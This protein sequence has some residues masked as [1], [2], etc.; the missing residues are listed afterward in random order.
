MTFVNISTHNFFERLDIRLMFLCLFFYQILFIFWGI[1]LADMGWMAIFCQQIFNDP[2]S[3]H[4]CFGR[5]LTGIV[6]GVWLHL[7]SGLGLLGLKIFGV[8]IFT[9]S[10][11]F[12]YNLL[13]DD[14]NKNM[15]KPG[16]IFMTLLVGPYWAYLG[17]HYNTITALFFILM[18]LFLFK[19]LKEK[20][21]SKIFVSGIFLC[22]NTFA[23]LPN[24]TGVVILLPVIYY[25]YHYNYSFKYQFKIIISFFLGFAL[26]FLLLV[27]LLK[28]LKHDK[29]FVDTLMGTIN[30]SNRQNTGNSQEEAHTVVNLVRIYFSQFSDILLLIFKVAIFSTIYLFASQFMKSK[31]LFILPFVISYLIY[32]LIDENNFLRVTEFNIYYGIVLLFSFF[33]LIDKRLSFNQ[34]FL[35]ILGLMLFFLLPIGSSHALINFE[36][37]F[38]FISLP[39][40]IEQFLTIKPFKIFSV[41][42][43]V[44]F[45][46][47]EIISLA[48]K[49]AIILS[50]TTCIVLSIYYS[51][52][53]DNKKYSLYYPIESPLSCGIFSSKDRADVVNEL[54]IASSKYVR[55]NDYVIAYDQIPMFYYLTGTKPFLPNFNSLA[56]DIPNGKTDILME[57]SI[58]EKKV[59]PVIIKQKINFWGDN[60]TNDTIGMSVRNNNFEKFI[61]QYPYRQVWEN[62][63]FQIFVPDKELR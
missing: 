15:L 60:F 4:H 25:A 23:R 6:G 3:I 52:C 33:S 11:F 57:K 13:R 35:T 26:A 37:L 40:A 8:L 14:F 20:N 27:V 63:A 30:M 62:N 53:E 48:Q 42:N 61:S 24:I 41:N 36:G 46:K 28:L 19:G 43:F 38:L 44:I 31:I 16:L 39:I 18:L 10:L 55:K 2:Q 51:Y 9:S 7:F 32:L 50:V 17:F 22:L 29:L 47:E 54:L 5:W 12:T 49:S 59:I 58:F 34:K 45:I 21:N 56:E 1:D